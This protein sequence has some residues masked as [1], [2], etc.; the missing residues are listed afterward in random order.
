MR[1]RPVRPLSLANP[2]TERRDCPDPD[3]DTVEVSW[4]PSGCAA[5]SVLKSIRDFCF[6]ARAAVRGVALVLM[7]GIL[8]VRCLVTDKPFF[9][10]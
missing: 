4:H 10:A 7:I 6:Y 8:T 1:A 2:A 9:A 3:E 5:M